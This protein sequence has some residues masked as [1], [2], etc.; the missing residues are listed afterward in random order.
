M[1]P[2]PALSTYRT[3]PPLRSPIYEYSIAIP[4]PYTLASKEMLA[5]TRI[6]GVVNVQAR[7]S[8]E[9]SQFDLV[10]VCCD[11]PDAGGLVK[12]CASDHLTRIA[13]RRRDHGKKKGGAEDLWEHIRECADIEDHEDNK[14]KPVEMRRDGT[15]VFELKRRIVPPMSAED[16]ARLTNSKMIRSAELQ[17]VDGETGL[18][19]LL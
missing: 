8:A 5:I 15:T 17:A 9:E 16:M 7:R 1:V 12:R 11:A 19:L 3:P 2:H 10:V 13:E 18:V 14:Q 4:F 6:K